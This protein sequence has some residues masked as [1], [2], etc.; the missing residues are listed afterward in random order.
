[1][2][3]PVCFIPLDVEGGKFEGI[4]FLGGIRL[5]EEI[6]QCQ[7]IA[8]KREWLSAGGVESS[9]FQDHDMRVKL[10]AA[11]AAVFG[12]TLAGSRQCESPVWQW[13]KVDA[14]AIVL[15]NEERPV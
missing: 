11:A 9:V 8:V 5:V 3:E 2:G 1:M 13:M 15:V 14:D 10:S 4:E 6:S 7:C 12:R